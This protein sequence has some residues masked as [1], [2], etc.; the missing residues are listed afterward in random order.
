MPSVEALTS[1]G[2][3]SIHLT[4]SQD[5]ILGTL[6]GILIIRGA[7]HLSL[8]IPA[9]KHETNLLSDQCLHLLSWGKSDLADMMM[10]NQ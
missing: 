1:T 6:M 8:Q 4:G 9:S 10:R 7:L 2:S 5:W 3:H